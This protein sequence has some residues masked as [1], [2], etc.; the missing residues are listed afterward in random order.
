[1]I[2]G[3]HSRFKRNKSVCEN[4][5]DNAIHIVKSDSRNGIVVFFTTK[6]VAVISDR[7]LVVNV[8]LFLLVKDC[9]RENNSYDEWTHV[10]GKMIKKDGSSKYFIQDPSL[11]FNNGKFDKNATLDLEN[12]KGEALSLIQKI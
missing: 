11:H 3:N 9:S 1:M 4:I 8:P 5:T 6:Y 2:F 10:V 7:V 12:L